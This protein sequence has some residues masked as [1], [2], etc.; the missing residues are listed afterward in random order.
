LPSQQPDQAQRARKI[1]RRDLAV[2][3]GEIEIYFIIHIRIAWGNTL[4]FNISLPE[5]HSE[6]H[7]QLK[8]PVPGRVAPPS[9]L[10]GCAEKIVACKIGE[11]MQGVVREG[12]IEF[13]PASVLIGLIPQF[14]GYKKT[15]PIREKF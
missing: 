11:T 1:N 5:P 4:P 6:R 9:K 7:L 13:F 2:R 12:V 8:S 3:T 14:A 10:N 15:S